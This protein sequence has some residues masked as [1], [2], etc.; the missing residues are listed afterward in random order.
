MDIYVIEETDGKITEIHD[1]FWE[2]NYYGTKPEISLKFPDIE[3]AWDKF[4]ETDIRQGSES[5]FGK[6]FK[7]DVYEIRDGRLSYFGKLRIK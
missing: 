1:D 7:N 5:D 2:H 4:M 6:D 3:S